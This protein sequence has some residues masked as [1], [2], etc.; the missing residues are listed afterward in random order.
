MKTACLLAILPLVAGVQFAAARP[1]T[2]TITKVQCV[3]A[4]DATGLEA[5]GESKPDF[6]AKIT[7]NGN[8]LVTARAPDDQDDIEPFWTHSVDIPAGQTTGTVSIQI[9]DYDSTSGDDLA[10][11]SPIDGDNNLDFT[12]NMATGQWS[13]DVNFPQ[14]CVSGGGND[15]PKVKICFAVSTLSVS[16]DAD[17]DGLLD[18]W[19]ITGLDLDGDGIIDVNLPAMGADPNHKDL[20]LELDYVAGQA[21][22]RAAVQAMKLAFANAPVNAGGVSNPDGKPGINLHVDTGTLFDPTAS[23]GPGAPPNSCSDGLDNNGDG[24]IDAAD[25]QCMVGDS[26]I[27]GTLGLGGGNAVPAYTTCGL[28]GGFYATKAANF[29]QNRKWVFRYAVSAS[30]TGASCT[31]SGGQGEVGGNDF[32]EFNH[33]GGT[34]MHELGH[35]LNLRHGGNEDHN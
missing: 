5:F 20:F 13:G 18:S 24:K 16:G 10:D 26:L 6:Y 29:N 25:P 22:N 27:N 14:S 7:I 3:D 21:I 15:E 4:C 8:T 19:E 31:P 34:V 2:V 35:T 33:N 11:I 28:D 30:Q 17:G 9:W 23:E 1:L 12:V 32:T